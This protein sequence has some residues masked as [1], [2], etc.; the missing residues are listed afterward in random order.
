MTRELITVGPEHPI[1]ECMAL[2]IDHHVRHLP[3]VV[4]GRAVGMLSMRDLV[5]HVLSEKEFVIR[6][7]TNYISGGLVAPANP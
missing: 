3:V 4:G 1:D 2:M 7:M 5:G 6:Q